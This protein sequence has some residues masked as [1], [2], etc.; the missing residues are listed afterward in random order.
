MLPAQPPSLRAQPSMITSSFAK[1][2]ISMN[3]SRQTSTMFGAIHSNF[4]NRGQRSKNLM[5]MNA[6]PNGKSSTNGINP[7]MYGWGSLSD[8]STRVSTGRDSVVMQA[9]L[10][11]NSSMV[12]DMAKRSLMNYILL[13]SLVGSLGCLG[14]PFLYYFYPAT[15]GGGGGGLTA[16]DKNGDDVTLKSWMSS[17]KEG[18]R[19]LV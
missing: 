16:K 14:G 8:S 4:Q 3:I 19:E 1:T 15:S 13:G 11:E 5:V 10:A 17:H 9:A 6:E 12:P 7:T 2:P 18:D